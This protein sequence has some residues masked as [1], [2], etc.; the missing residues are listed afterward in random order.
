MRLENLTE[1]VSEKK[2][3]GAV[4]WFQKNNRIFM[5]FMVPSNRNFG[6]DRPQI[7]KGG[8]DAGESRI[9]SAVREA[10]EELGLKASNIKQLLPQAVTETVQGDDHSYQLTVYAVEIKNAE[11]FDQPH[12][13]TGSVHWMTLEDFLIRGRQNQAS[14]VRKIHDVIKQSLD[15][16]D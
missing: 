8:Q 6:G 15:T 16:S 7:A 10:Q 9:H 11:D 3:F 4:P 1:A 13:E 12:Y 2:K 14:V 5:M